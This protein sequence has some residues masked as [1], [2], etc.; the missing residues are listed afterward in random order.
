MLLKNEAYIGD[1][2]LQK[3]YTDSNVQMKINYGTYPQYY[4][5]DH[6]PAI[7]SRDDFDTVKNLLLETGWGRPKEI[8]H[9]TSQGC[10]TVNTAVPSFTAL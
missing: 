3:C 1:L 8:N 6:H 4:L 10:C 7:I 5:K 2:L 9:H